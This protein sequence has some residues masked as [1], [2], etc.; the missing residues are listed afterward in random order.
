MLRSRLS[1]VQ[2]HRSAVQP[3]QN[4]EM[5]AGPTV[6]S[7]CWIQNTSSM[8]IRWMA[9]KQQPSEWWGWTHT[10]SPPT[11]FSIAYF[12]PAPLAYFNQPKA[13]TARQDFRVFIATNMCQQLLEECR[14]LHWWVGVGGYVE[15]VWS[16]GLL[17][18]AAVQVKGKLS[19]MLKR[20]AIKA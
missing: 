1:T 6:R 3:E 7:S 11:P 14:R 20:H 13:P 10:K 2:S 12:P 16:I 5:A 9:P 15:G 17:S 4:P 18:V 19:A 8:W